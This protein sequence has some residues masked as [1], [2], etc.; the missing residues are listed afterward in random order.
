MLTYKLRHIR[1]FKSLFEQKCSR[2]G[3]AK[4][5]VIRSAL[6]RRAKGKT[7]RQVIEAKKEKYMID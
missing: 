4:L 2:I 5:K 6:L 3:S 7:G 1:T